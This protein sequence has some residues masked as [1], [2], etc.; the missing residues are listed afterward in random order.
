[1]SNKRVLVTYGWVRSA[2]VIVRNLAKH[3]LEVYVGDTDKHFMSS[4]SRYSKGSFSYPQF[5]SKPDE[6][7]ACVVDF[8]EKY[9]IGT[10][11]PCHEEILT[12][13][14]NCVVNPSDEKQKEALFEKIS[15]VDLGQ[16]VLELRK[17]SKGEST[18]LILPCGLNPGEVEKKTECKHE[19]TETFNLN[20]MYKQTS[21]AI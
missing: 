6:F 15:Y 19:T 5:R 8:I 3:G 2:W 9:D 13:A 16:I 21:S 18:T 10:Y 17:M 1:M 11:I 14:K 20:E 7:V 4:L 12:V